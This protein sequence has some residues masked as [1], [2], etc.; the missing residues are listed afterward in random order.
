LFGENTTIGMALKECG[1]PAAVVRFSDAREAFHMPSKY[2]V[3]NPQSERY[4]LPWDE[5]SY[6]PF[7]MKPDTND[8]GFYA[9]IE[10]ISQIK[11]SGVFV[12]RLERINQLIPRNRADTEHKRRLPDCTSFY[13]EGPVED[14]DMRIWSAG[15]SHERRWLVPMLLSCQSERVAGRDAADP[16]PERLRVL[17]QEAREYMRS[18]LPNPDTLLGLAN[19]KGTEHAPATQ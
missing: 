1:T 13:M 19:P 6:V 2:T 17:I 16:S 3:S 8:S 18:Y 5:E 7:I 4:N 10:P 11:R 9:Y 14:G 15:W 12:M